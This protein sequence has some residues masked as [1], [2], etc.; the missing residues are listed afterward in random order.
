MGLLRGE[1]PHKYRRQGRL[2]PV[3]VRQVGRSCGVQVARAAETGSAPICESA[4]CRAGATAT[5]QRRPAVP[6]ACRWASLS[7]RVCILQHGDDA[8]A[9]RGRT[10]AGAE[11]AL[12]RRGGWGG[13]DEWG[14]RRVSTRRRA[15][16]RSAPSRRG[17]SICSRVHTAKPRQ[18]LQTL[19]DTGTVTQ[20][21][22][23]TLQG[24]G[25]I[26]IRSWEL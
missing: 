11:T 22:E 17:V 8:T 20:A 21:V 26:G 10:V 5:R 15:T 2:W 23:Q 14:G 18:T 24:L 19:T 9:G 3:F 6:L 13:R 1:A 7:P 25:K 4:P 16:S 12:S